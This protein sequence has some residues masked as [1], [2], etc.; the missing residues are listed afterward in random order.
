MKSEVSIPTNWWEDFFHGLFVEFWRAALPPDVTRAEADFFQE[1]LRLSPGARVLDVP[2]GDGRL[3][4]ELAG[5]G[6]RL[7]GVDIS[8]EFLHAA[9]R[10][11]S[12]RSLQIE[13]R[14]S[15]MRD[16]PWTGQFDGAF[17][18]G[19]SFGYLD[20]AGDAAFVKAVS[21]ALQP[22]GR[23]LLDWGWVAESV[24]PNFREKLEMEVGELR[25]AAENRYVAATG[26]IENRF[27]ITRREEAEVR[28]ASHRA[29][30]YSQVL[31]LFREA[32]F[33]A[34][35]ACGSL[36]GEPFGLGSPRLLL[37]ATKE[38]P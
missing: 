32:G 3:A 26:R 24:L 12:E 7:T 27:T 10:S 13:W 21:V 36:A 18:A 29:Y 6:Y 34:F 37:V 15:D 2:C 31:G 38:S 23:F 11:A 19:S 35:E 14:Q 5:R 9:R 33:S 16:L 1:R 22:G 28:F 30:T 17:C 4:L 20:D 8:S 25:F